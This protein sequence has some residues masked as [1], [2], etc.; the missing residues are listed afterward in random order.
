MQVNV[1]LRVLTPDGVP[2]CGVERT[3]VIVTT[4]DGETN[5][6]R[7]QGKL[8]E[9]IVD[10]H[11]AIKGQMRDWRAQLAEEASERPPGRR[12]GR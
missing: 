4:Q 10:A 1:V 6:D 5:V 9:L 3:D 12:L 11:G 8:D 7:A 2:I